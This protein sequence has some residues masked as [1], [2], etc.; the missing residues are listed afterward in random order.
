MNPAAA[1]VSPSRAP[2]PAR[3]D[4]RGFSFVEILVVMGIIAVLVGLGLAAFKIVSGKAPEVKTRAL[5]QK[6]RANCD[7]WRG[8][9]K[10]TLPSDL[11]KLKL[12]G[13]P[14][15]PG[16][17]QPPN[18]TNAEIESV[19]QCLTMPGF[20]HNPDI[21]GDLMNSDDDKLDKAFA[22][23]GQPDLYE[24]KDAWGNPLVYFTDADYANAEKNPPTLLCGADAL[25]NAG[26][27]VN[28]RPWRNQNPDGSPGSFAQSGGYQLYSMGPDGIPNT[29]D[30]ITAWAK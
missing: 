2:R 16:K 30:D 5:L 19:V 17:P 11:Q 20:D 1:P 9:Y 21:D 23:S 25:A 8:A 10:M 24:V 14:L 7:A 6:M 27:A 12:I 26:A 15:T 13:I 4:R 28:P 3:P 18:T 22:K 29:E